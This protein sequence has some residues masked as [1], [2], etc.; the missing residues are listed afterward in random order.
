[1]PFRDAL[2]PFLLGSCLVAVG[3]VVGCVS[4]APQSFGAEALVGQS[5]DE[6][7]AQ[8]EPTAADT[9][10][11]SIPWHTTFHDGLVAA[12]GTGKPVLLWLMNGHPLG[13]T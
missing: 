2:R 13:C 7:C 6:F 9:A 10:W 4:S 12:E 11:R 3:L 1:M 8:L 5:L